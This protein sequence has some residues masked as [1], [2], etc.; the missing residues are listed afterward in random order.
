MDS[1]GHIS[2]DIFSFRFGYRATFAHAKYNQ[3]IY[4]DT[5]MLQQKN[6]LPVVGYITLPNF[7]CI[8][9]LNQILCTNF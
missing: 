9:F 2:P 6:I 7:I 3:A 4:T 8:L 1:S 5:F